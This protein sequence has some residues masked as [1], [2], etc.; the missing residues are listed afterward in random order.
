MR[1]LL[2]QNTP[3]PL[4]HALLGHH[5][6]TAYERGWSEVSNGKL[7]AEAESAGF[8]VL[9]TS[10]QNIPYQQNWTGRRL[11]LLVLNPNDW[12]RN[13]KFKERI[14]EAVNSMQRATCVSLEIPRSE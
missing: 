9:I 13:R 4:R 8:D 5:V 12:T 10:D 1:V 3:A 11:G 7:I 14:L 6:A 2:D